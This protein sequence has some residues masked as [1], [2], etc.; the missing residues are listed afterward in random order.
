MM[1][2]YIL[3]DAA[4][5]GMGAIERAETLCGGAGVSLYDRNG[6]S[7]Y[8]AD[9]GPHI[10]SV[11]DGL[12]SWYLEN[13]YGN[14]WGMI[15][16]TDAGLDDCVKHLQQYLVKKENGSN[17]FFRFYDPR[18]LKVYLPGCNAIQLREF[19]GPVHCFITE[20]ENSAKAISFGHEQG[21]LKK[22]EIA[23]PTPTSSVI[24][25]S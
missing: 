20:G 18:V 7:G 21:V 10:F 11:A 13:G 4:R 19:F 14:A 3:L 16:L 8:L 2:Q 15:I 6:A 25:N 1:R 9:I 17:W 22:S 23:L 5:C 12:M 24:I